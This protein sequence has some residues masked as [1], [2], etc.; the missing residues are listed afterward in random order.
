ML[1]KITYNSEGEYDWSRPFHTYI[2]R[3]G[4]GGSASIRIT[5]TSGDGDG[6]ASIVHALDGSIGGGGSST[7]E[8]HGDNS[9]ALTVGD[10]PVHS[11]REKKDQDIFLQL[12]LKRFS[13]NKLNI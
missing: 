13:R 1:Y 9:W 12:S 5:V 8:R 11:L 10:N 3:P 4:W 6:E 7:S 2:S